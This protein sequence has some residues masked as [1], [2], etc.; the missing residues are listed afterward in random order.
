M[1]KLT[2]AI[3]LDYNCRWVP[4]TYFVVNGGKYTPIP[5]LSADSVLGTLTQSIEDPDLAPDCYQMVG[6]QR[7]VTKLGF[8]D[9]RRKGERKGKPV[10]DAI[11]CGSLDKHIRSYLIQPCSPKANERIDWSAVVNVGI[12]GVKLG[13]NTYPFVSMLPGQCFIVPF[14][15]GNEKTI[16]NR[17]SVQNKR[18]LRKWVVIKHTEF[19]CYEVARIK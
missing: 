4:E 13:P 17:V 15:E 12:Q 14:S 3:D 18:D 2:Y 8:S 16:R 19:E 11:L 5:W 9:K 6:D 7:H 10:C 1:E